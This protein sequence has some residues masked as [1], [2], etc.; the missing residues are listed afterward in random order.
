MRMIIAALFTSALA[1]PLAGAAGPVVWPAEVT[2]RV[3]EN[4]VLHGYQNAGGLSQGFPYHYEFFSD[5]PDIA[6]I[7]GFASGSATTRP[8][9][10]PR[11]G[12]VFVRAVRPGLAHV[13][14]R[15]HSLDLATIRVLPQIGPVVIQAETTQVRP[16]QQVVL[17]AV[18]PGYDRPA[19]F[20]WYHGRTNDITRPLQ[21]STD[22]QL[23]FVME[24]SEAS[25][26]WVQACAGPVTS[27]AEILIEAAVPP[28][29][30]STRH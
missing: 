9:P 12:K 3:G 30:R 22:P 27:V 24:S 13:R 8:D 2:I 19:T 16:G 17:V 5:A 4:V 28:R 29:R 25:Y 1:M 11:N 20:F 23:T 18:V 15:A 10:L 6:T 21:A 7:Q 26:I 14:I